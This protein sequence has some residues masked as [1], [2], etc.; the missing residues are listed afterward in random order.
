MNNSITS[1]ALRRFLVN[2][3]TSSSVNVTITLKVKNGEK[4]PFKLPYI[5]MKEVKSNTNAQILVLLKNPEDNWFEFEISSKVD[6]FE[7]MSS[8]LNLKALKGVD[9]YY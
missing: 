3:T 1:N 7:K 4:A 6:F 2:N 8:S 5:I 9:F